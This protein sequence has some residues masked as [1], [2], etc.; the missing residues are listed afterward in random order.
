MTDN[1]E[2]N[3]IIEHLRGQVSDLL[4]EQSDAQEALEALGQ[5]R[6]T[7]ARQL[8]DLADE[9]DTAR[10]SQADAEELLG[11]TRTERDVAEVRARAAEARVAAVKA[12]IAPWSIRASRRIRAALSDEAGT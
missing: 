2:R 3:A 11:E 8:A 9:R 6:N 12:V 10:Q 4:A 7:W 1:P 5:E